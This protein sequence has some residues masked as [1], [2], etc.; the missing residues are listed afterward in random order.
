MRKIAIYLC[1]LL[2]FMSGCKNNN[3]NPEHHDLIIELGSAARDRVWIYLCG[4]T[5]DF[6]SIDEMQKRKTLT[7]I[8]QK[9]NIKFLA[10]KPPVHCAEFDNKLCWPHNNREQVLQT[11]Q[12]IL[13]T[14]GNKKIS[15]FIGFSNGGFFLN[16]CAQYIELKKP[17]ISIGAAGYLH[18]ASVPNILYLLISKEDSYHYADA[19]KYYLKAQ[20][21]PL[22]VTL[23]E[24]SGGH[25][26]PFP[27]LEKLIAT[28]QL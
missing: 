4:L 26:I 25:T 22:H 23:Y 20:N 21:S 12:Y 13:D 9:N 8:G 24:Y 7:K 19:R 6:Y 3:K 2:I 27:L 1:M 16:Q 14:I 17:I 5:S 11:Y 18:N 15:G 28:L 10:I